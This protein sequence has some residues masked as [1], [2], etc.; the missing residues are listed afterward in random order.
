MFTF[1]YSPAEDAGR[2]SGKK[3]KKKGKAKSPDADEMP[4]KAVDFE[5]S[6]ASLGDPKINARR[7]LRKSNDMVTDNVSDVRVM[8]HINP[9]G[10]W[11]Q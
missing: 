7:D 3:S 10:K 6:A 11:R 9:K 4:D 2:G 1:V 5:A 8:Y